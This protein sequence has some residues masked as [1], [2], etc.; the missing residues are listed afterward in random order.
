MYDVY[1]RA[2]GAH[3]T[4]TTVGDVRGEGGAMLDESKVCQ[5]D[6]KERDWRQRDGR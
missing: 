2:Q 4:L 3:T 1:Y 5:V 6:K